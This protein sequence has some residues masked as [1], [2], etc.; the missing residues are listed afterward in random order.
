[1]PSLRHPRERFFVE[2]TPL[3]TEIGAFDGAASS[4][5]NR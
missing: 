3:P 5:G 1:M 4:S 2:G